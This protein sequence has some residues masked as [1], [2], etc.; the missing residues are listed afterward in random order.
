MKLSPNVTLS[1]PYTYTIKYAQDKHFQEIFAD[2]ADDLS[3]SG[4]GG[5][6]GLGD[7]DTLKHPT[8][9]MYGPEELESGFG[10]Y[11]TMIRIRTP[12]KK[13]KKKKRLVII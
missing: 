9:M 5:V 12:R 10:V 6:K 3:F 1:K 7:H 4:V 8:T 13:K 2:L 11:D